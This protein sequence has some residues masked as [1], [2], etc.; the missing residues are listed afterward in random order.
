VAEQLENG[1]FQEVLVFQYYRPSGPDGDFV[2]DPR[3]DADSL[4]L[5]DWPLCRVL[6]M[7]EAPTVETYILPSTNKPTGAG[8]PGTPLIAGTLPFESNN[9][10]SFSISRFRVMYLGGTLNSCATI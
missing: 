9:P 6:R 3:L 2:L 4:Y 1:T 8:E 7:N 5:A 10:A